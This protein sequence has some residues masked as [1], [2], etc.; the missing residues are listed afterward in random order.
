MAYDEFGT[1]ETLYRNFLNRP[2]F[3][4]EEKG[5]HE[6]RKGRVNKF[7]IYSIFFPVWNFSHFL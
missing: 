7:I 1:L 4:N 3:S 5:G 6:W 2:F